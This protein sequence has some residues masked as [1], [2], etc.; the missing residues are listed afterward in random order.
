MKIPSGFYY[1]DTD[2]NNNYVL[3]LNKNIY[4]LKQSALNWN[5][6]L[7][8]GIIH[9]W[10]KQNKTDP[11]S[12]LRSDIICIIYVDDNLLFSK[13]YIIIDGIITKI[14]QSFDLTEEGGVDEFLGIKVE[15]KANKTIIMYQPAL[16]DQVIKT[17]GLQHDSKIH[18][19][20]ATNP[21]LGCC[22][23]Q[24]IQLNKK[25]KLTTL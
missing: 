6:L 13:K 14:K 25:S 21:P 4:G 1:K 11:Y 8:E 15:N 7:I 5:K 17:L 23:V 12:F 2:G 24:K 16:I 10:F 18:K 9:L 22:K 3:N 19:T 20:P